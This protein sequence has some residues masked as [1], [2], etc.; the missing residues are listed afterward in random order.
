MARWRVTWGGSRHTGRGRQSKEVE[1]KGGGARA[2]RR[3]KRGR[4]GGGVTATLLPERAR[5][6]DGGELRARPLLL[7]PPSRSE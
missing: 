4:G 2:G 1:E 7:S 3:G 6:G 5:R